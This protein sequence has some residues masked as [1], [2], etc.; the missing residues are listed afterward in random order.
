MKG[1]DAIIPL[2]SPIC[3]ALTKTTHKTL[4]PS[5]LETLAK[6]ALMATKA[7]TP[8]QARGEWKKWKFKQHHRA[9]HGWFYVSELPKNH[10][11]Q[12]TLGVLM[13]VAT[14]FVIYILWMVLE[15]HALKLKTCLGNLTSTSKVCS[16]N[17]K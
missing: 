8:R 6:R 15:K 1:C 14:Y 17:Q 13:R 12:P 7:W 4:S 2:A 16:A 10:R 11:H 9:A 5:P 3:G